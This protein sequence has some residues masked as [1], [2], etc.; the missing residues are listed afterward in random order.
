MLS[1]K[2]TDAGPIDVDMEL[3]IT[4]EP[5]GITYGIHKGMSD[6]HYHRASAVSSTFVKAFAKPENTMAHLKAGTGDKAIAAS[7]AAIGTMVHA[8]VL[9]NRDVEFE[10]WSGLTRQAGFKAREAELAEENKK[11]LTA[12]EYDA[13]LGAIG[14][15]RNCKPMR[16]FLDHPETE[17]ELSIFVKD[18]VFDMTLKARAD[19]YN[20]ENG[21]LVDLKTCAS[22][23]PEVFVKA[24]YDYGY[25]LQFAFYERVA[26]LAGLPVKQWSIFCV[27]K[28]AP[29]ATNI[30]TFGKEAQEIARANLERLLVKLQADI[31]NENPTTGWP[32]FTIIEPPAWKKLQ[33]DNF[34]ENG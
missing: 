9:E 30:F 14:S 17:K 19:G 32:E 10:M 27:E 11:L 18:P 31:H 12:K 3:G 6:D 2:N 22:A 16:W 26:Q 21:Y 28:K 34:K 25:D 4:L 20:Q 24:V 13:A 5:D 29:F 7:T 23:A 8:A 1:R 15:V 33:F